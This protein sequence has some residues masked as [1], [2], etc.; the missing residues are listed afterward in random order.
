MRKIK[1]DIED[2]RNSVEDLL[3]LIDLYDKDGNLV[4]AAKPPVPPDPNKITIDE[5]DV[6]DPNDWEFSEPEFIGIATGENYVPP[7]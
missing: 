6:F 3:E 2:T 5:S 4:Y 1:P 7:T